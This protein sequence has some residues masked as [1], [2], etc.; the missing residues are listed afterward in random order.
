M[1]PNYQKMYAILCG[2]ASDA[3]DALPATAETL[4]GR[5]LLEQAL[6]EAEELYLQAE[7][8]GAEHADFS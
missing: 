1:E 5:A 8:D 6:E 7:G 4:A 2:A 3:L